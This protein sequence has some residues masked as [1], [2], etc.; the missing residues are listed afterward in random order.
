MAADDAARVRSVLARELETISEYERAARE[1][2]S[3]EVR[4]F[5]RHLAREEKEHVAEATA[6]LRRLD[7]EQE[8]EFGEAPANLAHFLGAAG[9][10]PAPR[11][12]AVV[13]PAGSGGPGG[14]AAG[15]LPPRPA[16][17][18][19]PAYGLTV[20]SLKKL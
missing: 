20:G 7:A 14:P 19:W 5:L 9:S 10:T 12:P 4:A 13:A 2:E 3:E 16:A 1:A 11:L 15:A 6:L 18:P 17:A 8:E